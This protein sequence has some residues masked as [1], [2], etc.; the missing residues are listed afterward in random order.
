MELIFAVF[1]LKTPLQV[2]EDQIKV[3]TNTLPF[4]QNTCTHKTMCQFWHK[5][6]KTCCNDDLND[7]NDTT[8]SVHS[9]T[10]VVS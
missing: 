7:Q 5:Y 3:N 1:P 8:R 2:I 4:K 10:W 6:S 9:A